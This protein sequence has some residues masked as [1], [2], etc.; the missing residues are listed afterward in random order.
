MKLPYMRNSTRAS[1]NPD[2][3]TRPFTNA[4]VRQ[5]QRMLVSIAA[6]VALCGLVFTGVLS[7][8]ISGFTVVVISV[9]LMALAIY[10]A[11]QARKAAEQLE[12]LALVSIEQ[13]QFDGL[14]RLP[15]RSTFSRHLDS[16]LQSDLQEN[17]IGVV[18]FDLDGFK[19][20]NDTLGHEAGDVLLTMVA[21]RLRCFAKPNEMIAR[22]GGDEFAAIV[23][24]VH[25]EERV[26]EYVELVG[27]AMNE[28]F[29][30]NDSSI[31]IGISAGI[32][33]VD[34]E[35]LTSG[36]ILRRADV[37]MYRAKAQ[38]C[39]TYRQYSQDMDKE[40]FQ[41]R[42]VQTKLQ[43]AISGGDLKLFYQPIVS[44]RSGQLAGAEALVRWPRTDGVTVSPAEFIPVAE[45]SGMILQLGRWALETALDQA[46]SWDSIPISVNVSPVQIRHHGFANMVGDCLLNAGVS[47]ERLKVEIT[48]GVLISHADIAEKV[49]HQLRDLGVPVVLDDF[50]AG[51][52]SL[53]YLR[54]FKFDT[55]KIDRSFIWDI[56]EGTQS[57]QLVRAIIEL[58]HGLGMNVV[59]EG[60]E[61]EEQ[62]A[63]LGLLG[64]D[65]LQGYHLGV[66]MNQDDFQ[67]RFL[68]KPQSR[69][70]LVNANCL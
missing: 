24:G 25:A 45:D 8:I 40:I 13:A 34:D 42:T 43:R 70:P 6:A 12:T 47:P 44:G 68:I 30:I 53:G 2:P 51:F 52:S 62:R 48:E 16:A 38:S 60:I 5:Q 35:N 26:A 11:V 20:V 1:G 55:I 64:C 18:F 46:K 14:T 17:P 28:P 49:I 50:G 41:R 3:M 32:A 56:R 27:Q 67:E 39:G 23:Q 19:E 36:E 37:A 66:P 63:V 9:G 59:A 15:N 57:T 61:N 54:R 33:I 29:A 7:P 65:L 31:N 58:S 22:L 69:M 10:N 21:E 4:L